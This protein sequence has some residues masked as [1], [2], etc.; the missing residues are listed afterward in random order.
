[1][2]SNSLRLLIALVITG[3]QVPVKLP[4]PMH[5]TITTMGRSSGG[6]SRRGAVAGCRTGGAVAAR[7]KWEKSVSLQSAFGGGVVA[8]SALECI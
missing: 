4:D 7:E 6:S 8:Q 5:S 1:M 2:G 3:A